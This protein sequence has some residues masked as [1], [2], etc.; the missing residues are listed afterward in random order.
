MKVLISADM[1]KAR[2]VS[3]IPYTLLLPIAPLNPGF[4]TTRQSSTGRVG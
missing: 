4:T 2:R 3:H 1:E